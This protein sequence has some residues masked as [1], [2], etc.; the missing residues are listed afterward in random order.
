MNKRTKILFG[1]GGALAL[2]LLTRRRTDL[3]IDNSDLGKWAKDRFDTFDYYNEETQANIKEQ[4]KKDSPNYF[5]DKSPNAIYDPFYDYSDSPEQLYVINQTDNSFSDYGVEQAFRV[6]IVPSSLT[7]WGNIHEYTSGE[8]GDPIHYDYASYGIACVIEIF[9]PFKFTNNKTNISKIEEVFL[10]DLKM[11]G[12]SCGNLDDLRDNGGLSK[13]LSE[14]NYF[15]MTDEN[16]QVV[17]VKNAI[18]GG[19]SIFIPEVLSFTPYAK[20][21]NPFTVVNGRNFAYKISS[22]ELSY[23]LDRG[24]LHTVSFCVNFKTTN[25]D[26]RKNYCE[27]TVG[28]T[29]DTTYQY[30]A[31]SSKSVSVQPKSF[32]TINDGGIYLRKPVM[33]HFLPYKTSP[34][35]ADVKNGFVESFRLLRMVEEFKEFGE[36]DPWKLLY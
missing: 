9:N 24:W 5:G 8:L 27:I 2:W 6:R 18:L 1:A 23:T 35:I 17:T 25:S 34:Q 26:V 32:F 31:G 30:S 4:E 3:L 21:G 36:L 10:S 19:R 13:F 12:I 33:E 16:G 15:N 29:N 22:D 28:K 11:N 7:Y 14:E 20:K